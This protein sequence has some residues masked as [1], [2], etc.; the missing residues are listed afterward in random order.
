MLYL[1]LYEILATS[2]VSEDAEARI[3][4]MNHAPGVC[5]ESRMSDTLLVQADHGERVGNLN[6]PPLSA[7]NVF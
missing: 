6:K 3:A 7:T 2:R 5:P 1:V 4:T